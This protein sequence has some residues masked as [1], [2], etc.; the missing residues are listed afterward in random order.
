MTEEPT[1]PR[2][3]RREI[4]IGALLTFASPLFAQ[5]GRV[6]FKV[7]DPSGAMIPGA[8]IERL[9]P[10]NKVLGTVETNA[11]G[12]V[13]WPDLPM[14][15]NIFRISREGFS[16]DHRTVMISGRNEVENVVALK[17]PNLIMGTIVTVEDPVP[18]G[19]EPAGPL[20]ERAQ[21][22]IPP[23]KIGRENRRLWRIFK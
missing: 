10:D 1:R 12:E 4:F 16:S 9:G 20:P 7:T 17:V 2:R 11:Q 21:V 18:P 13:V 3:S 19:L 23:P 5:S 15:E 6:R 14:G 22:L 8:E